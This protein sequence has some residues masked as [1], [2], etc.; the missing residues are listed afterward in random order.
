M[1]NDKIPNCPRC[2][3]EN[4]IKNGNKRNVQRYT[5]RD[6]KRSFSDTTLP[7][8]Q[9]NSKKQ[10]I[11]KSN[12]SMGIT[13]DQLRQKHDVVYILSQV[14]VKIEAE[15]GNVF[16][17]KSDIIKRANLSPGYPGISTV[18]ESEDFKKYSGRAGSTM[19]WGKPEAI[20]KLKEEGIMR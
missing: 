8:N 2:G 17:E 1:K 19:Y 4:V 15:E 13:E 18:L 3:S 7:G 9:F 11:T 6:C 14:F 12:K 20:A 16:Y 10:S 5:C